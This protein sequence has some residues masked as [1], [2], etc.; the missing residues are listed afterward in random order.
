MVLFI[1]VVLCKDSRTCIARINEH[2]SLL[3]DLEQKS[4]LKGIMY[5]IG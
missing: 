4:V 5:G 2:L 1:I 3:D